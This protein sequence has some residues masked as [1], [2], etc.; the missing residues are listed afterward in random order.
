IHLIQNPDASISDL[1][2]YVIGPD[3][4]TGASI[5]GR[6]G[7][8]QA[9]TTGRGSVLM[10][11]RTEIEQVQGSDREQIVVTELPY[12][13]NKARLAAKIGELIRE[14]RIEGIREVRD[15]SDR[16]GMRLVIELKK[17]TFPQVVLNHLFRL[18]DLQ[19]SFGIINLAIVQGRP[20]VMN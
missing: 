2:T 10:R 12:Q 7:I 3:F 9:Y 17:D 13:V 8:Y 5:Y 19:S 6:A 14:K 20:Q 18:T 16:D 4:P 15:E 11:A 1:M